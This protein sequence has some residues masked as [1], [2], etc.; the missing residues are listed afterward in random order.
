MKGFKNKIDCYLSKMQFQ[1][2]NR[3]KQSMTKEPNSLSV[4]NTSQKV[5]INQ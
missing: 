1:L 5:G 2:F 4:D 3:Q